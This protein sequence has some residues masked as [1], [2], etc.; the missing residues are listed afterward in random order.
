[1][2]SCSSRTFS[3]LAYLSTGGAMGL[4]RCTKSGI[5]PRTMARYCFSDLWRQRTVEKQYLAIVRGWMPDFVHLDKPMAP[6]AD[7]YAKHEKVREE[8]E[9][10][11]ERKSVV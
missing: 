4:S 11:T 7:K 9:A 5:Q 10:I 1:M 8:Q 2:A 6:P 3:C